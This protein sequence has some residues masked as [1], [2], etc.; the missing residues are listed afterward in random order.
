VVL[1]YTNPR[2]RRRAAEQERQPRTEAPALSDA[3][4][5]RLAADLARRD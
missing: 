4:Q 5:Q 3:D 1:A 2:W